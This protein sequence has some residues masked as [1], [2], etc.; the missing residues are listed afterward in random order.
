[1]TVKDELI[2]LF[3]RNRGTFLSGADIADKLGCT[4]G[5]VWKAGKR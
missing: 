2:R 4:R 3:E 1:M 5:A